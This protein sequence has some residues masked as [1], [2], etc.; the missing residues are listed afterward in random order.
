MGKFYSK[1]CAT[2]S[3]LIIFM[4]RCEQRYQWLDILLG[5]GDVLEGSY[6]QILC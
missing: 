3:S 2:A 5:E 6:L 4:E 1:P